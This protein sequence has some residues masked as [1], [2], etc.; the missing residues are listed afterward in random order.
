MPTT[1]QTRDNSSDAGAYAAGLEGEQARAAGAAFGEGAPIYEGAK[2]V[3]ANNENGGAGFFAEAHHTA[4]LNI[5]ANYKDLSVNAERLGSTAFGSPDI[6]L[7]NGEQFNPKFY[8]TA[9]GSYSAGAELVDNG[10]GLAAKYAGQT[11]IVPSDQLDA[12]QNLH[13]EAIRDAYAQNEVAKAHALESISYDDHIHS[14]GVKSQ[15]LTYA[16]AQAGADGIRHGDLPG[17]VGDDTGLFGTAGG[18]A[19][20]AASIALATTIGPQLVGDAAKVLRGQLTTDEAIARLH[21]SFGEA[22]T[23]STLGWASARGAGAAALTFLDATDPTGAAFLA[24]MVIDTIQLSA[25]LKDGSL[26]PGEFGS[27]M[28]AKVKDRAAYTVLTAGAVW[29]VG[30]VGLL[31]PIIVRRMVSDTALQREAIN[32]WNG[33]SAAMRAELESR[34]K[35]AA[36]LDKIGQ[37]Y[38][39]ADA[40]SAGSTRAVLAI[41][42]DLSDVQKLLGCEPDPKP[43]SAA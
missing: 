15:P 30:P 41:A 32:A 7:N 22:H 36:L 31:V 39:N 13:A 38:R 3:I 12:V 25:S 17:Y 37:H 28:L 35:G 19:M 10:S 26:S 24:N 40:S 27:A 20:L 6:V 23:R 11:I 42:D 9:S 43:P 18:S 21:R 34:I 2:P 4:S 1:T 16:E 5:D 33:V 14:G 29:L 8:D